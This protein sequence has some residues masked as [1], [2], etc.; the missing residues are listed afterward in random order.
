MASIHM[1]RKPQKSQLRHV[2]YKLIPWKDG[3]G[4]RIG[5]DC[6]SMCS[7]NHFLLDNQ[8]FT[9][10]H[11]MVCPHQQYGPKPLYFWTDTDNLLVVATICICIVL[12]VLTPNLQ[13]ASW[14]FGHFTDGSGWG[15]KVFS[16]FLGFLSVAWTMTDYDGTTQ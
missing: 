9:S 8:I 2:Q 7:W 14:V 13:P 5:V 3:I 10:D 6:N 1:H 15:S 16:F 4:D 11:S 12:L